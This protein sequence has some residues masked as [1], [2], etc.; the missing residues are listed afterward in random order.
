[1]LLLAA[2]Q[3]G[4]AQPQPRWYP[5]AAGL[6]SVAGVL[7]GGKLRAAAADTGGHVVA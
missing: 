4:P 5:I 7:L 6:M 3:D 2:V 1:V